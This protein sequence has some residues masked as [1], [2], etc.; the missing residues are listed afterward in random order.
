M[1]EAKEFGHWLIIHTKDVNTMGAC[2]IYK[3]MT[4]N[5]DELY[6]AWQDFKTETKNK[7]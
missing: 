7:Y 2:R 4:L 3:N 6:D 1:N 5:L